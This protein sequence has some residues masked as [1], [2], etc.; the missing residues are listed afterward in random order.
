[1]SKTIDLHPDRLLPADPTTREVARRIYA[2]TEKLPIISPH[3]HVPAGWLAYNTPF[4]DP[5]SLLITPDHYVNRMLHAIGV[6][7]KELGVGQGPLSEAAARAAFKKLCDNWK[8]Y[9][10]TPVRYWLEDELVNTFG[11]TERPGPGKSD[12]IYDQIS[13]CLANDDFKP[14]A[15]FKRFNIEFLAT[16]DDPCD[17]LEEHRFIKEEA[18]LPGQVVP[19]FRPDKYLEPAGKDWPML[20]AKLG[21]SSGEDISTYA[22]YDRA[23]RNRREYFKSRG[24]VSSDHSH[25]DLGTDRLSSSEAES[26]YQAALCGQIDQTTANRLRQHMLSDQARMAVDD[27]LVMTLHPAVVRGHDHSSTGEYGNDIGCDIPAGVEVAQGLRPLLNDVGN[28]D[29]FHLVVFTMDETV[30]S[31]E[32]APLAGWY[33]S[34]YVGAPWWFIDAPEAIR[35]YRLDTMETA[36][37]YRTSGF[38]D[39]TRAFCSIPA[40]HDL[41]RR[42]DAGI[43]ASLVVEHRLDEDEAIETGID[44]VKTIPSDVF[45]LNK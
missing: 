7:L 39:D 30:Y 31:R 4:E 28:A 6:D 15:L 16:T 12:Q 9:R 18:P 21:E 40:R 42:I 45:K 43:L 27:G 10:A 25:W 11:V 24:A 20:I 41:A 26:A 22:G 19:T 35:R 38:I 5:T 3:G 34:V 29:G 17:S 33:R 1:M 13:A 23:M 37:F 36:G 44:L 2:Q 14:R 32:L 8:Y